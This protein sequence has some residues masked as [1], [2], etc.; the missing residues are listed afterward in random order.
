MQFD[1]GPL[2]IGFFKSESHRNDQCTDSIAGLHIQR[3]DLADHV[4]TGE[5]ARTDVGMGHVKRGLAA[6]FGDFGAEPFDILIETLDRRFGI[7]RRAVALQDH[8]LKRFLDADIARRGQ[9]FDVVVPQRCAADGCGF[10][11]QLQ[12]RITRSHQ[13][14]DM[15]VQAVAVIKIT[16]ADE[17]HTL[18]RIHLRLFDCR[19][20]GVGSHAG[21]QQGTQQQGLQQ[22]LDLEIHWGLLPVVVHA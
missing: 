5:L 22:G 11:L 10:V 3:F 13:A 16:V 18:G 15:I 14:A 4:R 20:C 2:A 21:G 1:I 8:Q 7:G 9:V 17:Q 6:T 12:R 19:T